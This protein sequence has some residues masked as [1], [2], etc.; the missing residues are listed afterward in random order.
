M[1]ESLELIAH[2]YHKQRLLAARSEDA[3]Y[4][5]AIAI[6]GPPHS[7]VRV[8]ANSLI[9]TLNGQLL[10]NDH[11]AQLVPEVAEEDGRSIYSLSTDSPLR[12]ISGDLEKLTLFAGQI[13][14]TI[15]T[16]PTAGERIT[17]IVESALATLSLLRGEIVSGGI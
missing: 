5:D 3:V 12:I 8:I 17:D 15:D 10:G 11:P 2:D 14:G 7:T 1:R 16:S 4:T 6:N 13:A 9:E